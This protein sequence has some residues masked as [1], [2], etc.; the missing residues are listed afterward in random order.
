MAVH[1]FLIVTS[2]WITVWAIQFF[3]LKINV[4]TVIITDACSMWLPA[5][6]L[7]LW[8]SLYYSFERWRS[9]LKVPGR[10]REILLD[11]RAFQRSLWWF[12]EVV[13][14][15]TINSAA[16]SKVKLVVPCTHL[17]Q[18]NA[19]GRVVWSPGWYHDHTHHYVDSEPKGSEHYLNPRS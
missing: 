12:K 6:S 17:I 14:C 9:I 8:L 16:A 13:A 2:I 18:R 19:A 3:W 11:V 4:Y 1:F 5:P 15:T 7:Q 10:E